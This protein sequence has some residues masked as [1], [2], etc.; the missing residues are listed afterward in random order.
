MR[1]V[2]RK[3][4]GQAEREDLVARNVAALSMP[5]RLNTGEGR[6]LTV[7]QSHRLL[8]E[9]AE[10]RNISRPERSGPSTG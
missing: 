7:D 4:L 2:L 3:A 10:Q 1:A 6:T 8:D 9:V 5:P